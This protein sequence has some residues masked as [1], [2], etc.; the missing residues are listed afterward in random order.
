M[1]NEE[2][3]FCALVPES[4]HSKGKV[5]G[6]GPDS[7]DVSPYMLAFGDDTP[8]YQVLSMCTYEVALSICYLKLN[9]PF[10][11]YDFAQVLGKPMPINYLFRC[12]CNYDKCNELNT[13]DNYLTNL[14]GTRR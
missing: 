4:A 11:R 8:G 14:A 7:D 2:W 9:I 3:T 13:F 1:T 12:V 5:F 6:L 10:Q